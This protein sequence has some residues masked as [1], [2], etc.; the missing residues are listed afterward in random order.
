[1]TKNRDLDYYFQKAHNIEGWFDLEAAR[2]INELN[3]FQRMTDLEGDIFEIGVHHGRM[4]VFLGL[5]LDDDEQIGVC[6]IFEDQIHNISRSGGGSRSKFLETW[7]HYF[8]NKRQVRIFELP[9]QNLSV[10][11]TGSNCRIFSID[12]GHTAAETFQDLRTGF[13]AIRADGIV[14]IDDYFDPMYPGVSEGVNRFLMD[15]QEVTPLLYFFNKLL[16]LNHDHRTKYEKYIVGPQFETFLHQ[17]RLQINCQKFHDR[18]LYILSQS[19]R[20]QLIFKW[21]RRMIPD[22]IVSSAFFQSRG[23]KNIYSRLIKPRK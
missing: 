19:T 15:T 4:T 3:N 23:P 18:D 17:R 7:N 16:L 12:G 5:L 8:G 10:A 21:I 2:I 14:L 11:D 1:M 20:G 22:F 9:S 6:D 13:A